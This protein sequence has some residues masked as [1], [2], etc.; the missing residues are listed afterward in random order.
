M[1]DTGR[2]WKREMADTDGGWKK[3]SFGEKPFVRTDRNMQ[4]SIRKLIL[5]IIY[6]V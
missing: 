5:C 1:T 6:V 4:R 3:T 2:G